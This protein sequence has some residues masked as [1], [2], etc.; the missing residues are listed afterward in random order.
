MAPATGITLD[1]SKAA[2]EQ[3]A[4]IQEMFAAGDERPRAIYETIGCYLGY[5]IAHYADFYDI[6]HLLIMG[7]VTSGEG[8]QIILKKAREV[9]DAEFPE[10]AEQINMY[11]PDESERRVGQ[12]IA[13]ASLP[14]IG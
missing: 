3:L 9:L 8:G 7:R 5:A 14:E 12:A 2:P 4:H 6:R 11:L 1:E 13:A 10:L